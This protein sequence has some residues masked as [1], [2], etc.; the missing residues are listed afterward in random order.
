MKTDSKGFE[1]A[2]PLAFK[3]EK[4][5]MSQGLKAMQL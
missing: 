2:M 3:M 1:D 4:A 5:G